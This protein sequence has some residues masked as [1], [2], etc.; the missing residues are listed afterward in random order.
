MFGA[1]LKTRFQSGAFVLL[2]IAALSSI[3]L[4]QK[5]PRPNLS[6][7]WTMDNDSRSLDLREK[8][9]LIE[10]PSQ[11]LSAMTLIISHGDSDGDVKVVRKFTFGDETEEQQLT[12]HPDGRGETNP[13]I[14]SGKRTFHS[15]TR[16]EKDRLSIRFD[17][18]PAS[19]SGRPLVAHRR[20]EWRVE[21][22][23]KRLV[24]TDTIKYEQSNFIDSSVSSGDLRQFSILPPNITVRRVYQ[25]VN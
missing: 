23:G 11:N 12:Y 6:G 7:T 21:D 10:R 4:S 17:S 9:M 5:S 1:Y 19:S 16:W 20:V 8:D 15:Q 13:G 25:R 18:F 22:G 24:E 3:A 14:R 2:L